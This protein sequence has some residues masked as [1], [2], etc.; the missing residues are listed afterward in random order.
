MLKQLFRLNDTINKKLYNIS[1]QRKLKEFL[2]THD[3][4]EILEWL[5][6]MH[7]L[8]TN[9]VVMENN[10]MYYN[11]GRNDFIKWLLVIANFNDFKELE[12]K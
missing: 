12:S 9:T 10:K 1:M 8:D 6:K 7:L 4:M 11:S 5:V 3:G 2:N